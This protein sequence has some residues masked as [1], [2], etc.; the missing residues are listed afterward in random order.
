MGRKNR[1]SY[2]NSRVVPHA[3]KNGNGHIQPRENGRERN[4]VWQPFPYIELK[5]KVERFG[6]CRRGY[7]PFF[8]GEPKRS[9]DEKIEV[10]TRKMYVVLHGWK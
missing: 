6:D 3:C 5:E 4:A 2:T 8:S 1:G 9:I 7:F 10:A